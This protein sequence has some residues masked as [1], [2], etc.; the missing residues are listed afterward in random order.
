M[1]RE[2]IEFTKNSMGVSDVALG[3]I[4]PDNT[5]AIIAVQE[6]SAAPLEIQRRNLHQAVE[7]GVLIKLDL[8]REF[9]GLRRIVEAVQTET[10][11]EVSVERDFDFGSVDYDRMSI[12]VNVGATSYWSELLAVETMDSL[13]TKGIITDAVAYLESLPEGFVPHRAELIERLRS[14]NGAA[15]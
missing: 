3:Q 12:K 7:D 6:A 8:I 10:G 4:R 2:T 14:Q 9:Y 15:A 13:F 5:S 11:E 1:V